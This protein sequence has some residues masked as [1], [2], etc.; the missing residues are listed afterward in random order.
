[1]HRRNQVNIICACFLHHAWT[2][3][4]ARPMPRSSQWPSPNTKAW[5][6]AWVPTS[7]LSPKVRFSREGNAAQAQ[8][9]GIRLFWAAHWFRLISTDQFQEARLASLCTM[10]DHFCALLV[11][12]SLHFLMKAKNIVLSA[13]PSTPKVWCMSYYCSSPGGLES[14][15]HS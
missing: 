11:Y 4:L 12:L 7:H 15:W 1:M 3:K 13:D 14:V 5:S 6:K 9:K 8:V 10:A 2:S